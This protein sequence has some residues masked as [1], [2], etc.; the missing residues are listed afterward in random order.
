MIKR[1]LVA[2]DGS[3]LA[4]RAVKY[5][6]ELAGTLKSELIALSVIDLPPM[7]GRQLVT[8]DA[9]PTH[10]MEPLEDYMKQASSE[11]MTDIEASCARKGVKFR[12]ITKKGHPVEQIVGTARQMKVNM[13]VLGSHGRSALGSVLLGSVTLGVINRDINIPVLIIR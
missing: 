12:A 8:G 6:V 3:E 10:L 9:S 11:L 7:Y 2:T 5:A 4:Q 1:I 13:I